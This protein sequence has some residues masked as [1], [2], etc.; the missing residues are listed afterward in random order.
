[1]WYFMVFLT[2]FRQIL[3]NRSRPHR[4]THFTE[5]HRRCFLHSVVCEVVRWQE[6]WFE[7]LSAFN[8]WVPFSKKFTHIGSMLEVWRF[9]TL[10]RHIVLN[11]SFGLVHRLD[12]I[13]LQ[14]FGCWFY[15]H[16][17]VKPG[18]GLRLA[19]PGGPTGRFSVLLFYL[20]T[21]VGPPSKTLFYNI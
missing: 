3:G 7:F 2:S 6:H 13:K 15:F 17:Q 9:L 4:S 11:C 19:Q 21:K 12:V 14:R 10:A 18:P 5:F 16:H 8:P 20:L 1:M